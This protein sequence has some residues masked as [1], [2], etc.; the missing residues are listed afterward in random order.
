[1]NRVSSRSR[2]VSRFTSVCFCIVVYGEKLFFGQIGI[3]AAVPRMATSR[4]KITMLP[5]C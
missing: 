2:L 5:Y 3:V 4:R 1:M